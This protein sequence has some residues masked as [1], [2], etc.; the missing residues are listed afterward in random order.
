MQILKQKPIL[1]SLR[2]YKKISKNLLCKN[3]NLIKK[4]I[5]K[6]KRCV[7]RSFVHGCITM[8]GRSTGSKR[9]YRNITFQTKK[10]IGLLL[11]STYDPNRNAF[12]S[13][14]FNIITK[15]FF[16]N[17]AISKLLPG[18]IIMTNLK[19]FKLYLGFRTSLSIMP[20]G[21]IFH[22]L[23]FKKCL[24]SQYAKSAG[25]YCQLIDKLKNNCIV[26][27]PSGKLINI[28]ST[29]IGTLGIISNKKYRFSQLGKAGRNRLKGFKPKVR[30]IAMNPVDHPHGG[31]TNGGCP[32][33]TPWGKPTRGKKTVKN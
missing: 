7:G 5:Y 18:S 28:L 24:N 1:P 23:S 14:F 9:L 31:R 25:V 20:H 22:L 27:L 6:V 11:F 21:S 26:R 2:H 33:V 13:L 3:N 30:G 29:S 8:R 32:S 17:I 10:Q 16:Y 12:I 4:L 15:T 19:Q